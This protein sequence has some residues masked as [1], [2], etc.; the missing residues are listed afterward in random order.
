MSRTRASAAQRCRSATALC[1]ILLPWPRPALADGVVDLAGSVRPGTCE[2][3]SEDQAKRVDLP[4]VQLH[5]IGAATGVVAATALD[6]EFRLVNCRGVRRVALVFAG[7]PHAA[8]QPQ[9]A[10]HGTATGVSLH[11]VEQGSE[12]VMP[13][14][15][16]HASLAVASGAATY[17]GRSYFYRHNGSPLQHGSFKSAA[18][19]VVTYD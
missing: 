5:V 19:V 9:Y 14:A 6:W 17:Q 3:H 15:G 8:G 4:R 16:H 11:L 10:N 12:A 18:T 2:V 13:A 7:P 1:V